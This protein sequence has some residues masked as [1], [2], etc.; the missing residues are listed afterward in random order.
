MA[1]VFKIVRKKSLVKNCL[2]VSFLFSVIKIF[3]KLINN[4]LVVHLEKCGRFYNFL[5]G[6]RSS[7]STADLRLYLIELLEFLK[8]WGNSSCNS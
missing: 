6:F 4:R 2:H 3:E 5:Y 7:P 1:S 8:F